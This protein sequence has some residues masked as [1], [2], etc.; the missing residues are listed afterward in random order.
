MEKESGDEVIASSLVGSAFVV[1][2]CR[3][4]FKAPR[5]AF[6]FPTA[7]TGGGG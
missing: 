6:K 5:S 3:Q 1:F 7:Q 4:V 2:V